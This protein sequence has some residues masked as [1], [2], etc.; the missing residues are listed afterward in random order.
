MIAVNQLHDPAVRGIVTN[1]RDITDR[2]DADA[3][4]PRE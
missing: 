4:D 3:G 1:C 2:V